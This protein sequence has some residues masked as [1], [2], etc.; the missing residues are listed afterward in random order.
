MMGKMPPIPSNIRPINRA[1]FVTRALSGVRNHAF[2]RALYSTRKTKRS[3]KNPTFRPSI[4]LKI[5]YLFMH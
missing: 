4:C 1:L 5:L 2:I 3:K